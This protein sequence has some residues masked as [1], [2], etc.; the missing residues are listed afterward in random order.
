[1]TALLL[2]ALFCTALLFGGMAFFAAIIAPLVF[3]LLPPDPAGRFLRGVFPAYY[4]WVLAT[5]AAAAISL[6]PLSKFDSGLMAAIAALTLWL[7]QVL[8]PRINALSDRAK[9]GD[10]RARRGFD[11]AHRL[12]V[13]ANLVQL[14]GAGV[15]LA[16]FFL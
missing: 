12:S 13:A 2:I 5:S 3:R 11:L 9:A 15:V 14:L 6:F 10:E 8:M 7:R 16:G 1:M 4:L